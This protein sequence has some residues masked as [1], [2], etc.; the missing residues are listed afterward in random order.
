[1]KSLLAILLS[2]L[3]A[4][5]Q[6]AAP[7]EHSTYATVDRIE[8]KNYT[9]LEICHNGEYLKMIDILQKDFNAP[10]REGEHFKFTAVS[11]KFHETFTAN[12]SKGQNETLYQFRSDDNAVWWVLTAE[13]IG[14][15]PNTETQYTIIFY[16]NGTTAENKSCDCMPGSECECDVYDDIFVGIIPEK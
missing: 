6:T 7:A 3:M 9:V 2:G 15:I 12:N 13:E 14:H 8:D 10:K 11:G 16:N 4:T 1:M 5:A